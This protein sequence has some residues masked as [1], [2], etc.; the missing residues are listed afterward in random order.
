MF[1]CSGLYSLFLLKKIYKE[2][3]CTVNA[4]ADVQPLDKML[5]KY[6]ACVHLK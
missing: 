6:E 5:L 3:Y 4:M 2:K 1:S